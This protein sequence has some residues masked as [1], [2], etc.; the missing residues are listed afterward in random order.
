MIAALYQGT[1]HIGSDHKF[2]PVHS[3]VRASRGAL[4]V[5]INP[6]LIRNNSMTAL[7][8]AGLG[9]FGPGEQSAMMT[10]N[11]GKHGVKP[12]D[13][14]HVFCSHLHTDHIGGL[15]CEQHGTFELAFPN[16]TIW[17]SGH[18]WNRFNERAEEKNHQFTIR[19]ANYLETYADLRFVEDQDPEPEQIHMTTIGGHTEHHQAVFYEAPGEKAI[20]LGDV[21]ARPEIINRRFIAK[22]DYDGKKSQKNREI[23]LQKAWDEKYLLL[24][25][26]SYTYAIVSIDGYD[27]TSG[28]SFSPASKT[29][30]RD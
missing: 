20:M 15:L 29:S 21:L 1:Y 16:A 4:K 9:P 24:T 2:V 25:Y 11:L 10:N 5:G 13:I 7:I 17:M 28:Y 23:Y 22:F 3:G 12:A 8:D 26:H 19:W 14:E 30:G 18:E 6:F 27:E